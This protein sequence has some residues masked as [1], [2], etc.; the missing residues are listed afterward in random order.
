MFDRMQE[1]QL[2]DLHFKH[3][4]RAHLNAIIAIHSCR[5]GAALGGC[6]F[7]PYKQQGDAITDAINLARSMSYKAALA[8]LPQGGGKA[9]IMLPEQ[10]FDRRQ[11]LLTFADFVNE[12]GG[13]YIT[14]VDSGTTTQ[15]MDVLASRS[16]YVTSTSAS[17]NPSPYTAKGVLIGIEAAVASKLQHDSLKGIH[18]A[19]QGLGQVG[20]SL[21]QA[22]HARGARLTVTDTDPQ[23]VSRAQQQFACDSVAPADIFSVTADVLAPCALG[24]AINSATLPQLNC[25]IIAGS[26]N[27][28]LA[29]PEIAQGLHQRGILYAPDYALNAGGLIF[30]SLRHY[31]HAELEAIEKKIQ[32]IGTTLKDIF[33][34]AKHQDSNTLVVSERLAEAKLLLQPPHPAEHTQQKLSAHGNSPQRKQG[35]GHAPIH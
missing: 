4:P 18:I 15:D 31:Q 11:L 27:N 1:S 23:Q 13:R 7:L 3:N 12:L 29:T 14:A 30:V 9:V 34:Q 25:S 33:L 28:Q 2:C 5:R 22:A 17:G 26:A 10:P 20:M 6:R 19:I 24:G 8:E 32:H 35:A 21:A 16:Q